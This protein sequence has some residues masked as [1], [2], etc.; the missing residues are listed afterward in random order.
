MLNKYFLVIEHVATAKE[1]YVFVFP[2]EV[3]LKRIW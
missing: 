1:N 3:N 2:E